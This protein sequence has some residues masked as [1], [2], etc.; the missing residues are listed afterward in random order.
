MTNEVYAQ[1]FQNVVGSGFDYL[2][3]GT[4]PSEMGVAPATKNTLRLYD[5]HTW[6]AA[7]A[8]KLGRFELTLRDFSQQ[9]ANHPEG[10]FSSN[11]NGYSWSTLT[12]NQRNELLG[13]LA[14]AS[15]TH[16]TI[17]GNKP[18]VH[19]AYAFSTLFVALGSNANNAL[20]KE[21]AG[22]ILAAITF[23][24]AGEICSLTN[25]LA[26][27]AE[28][29]AVG[30]VGQPVRLLS[31][32][33]G[34]VATTMHS[35]T[36]SCWGI[37]NSGINATSSSGAPT[38][39]M[40]CGTTVGTKASDATLTTAITVTKTG[41]NAGGKAVGAIRP[42]GGAQRAFWLFPKVSNTAGALKYGAET[43]MDIWS[44]DMTAD[45]LLPLWPIG[46]PSNY[47]P[48]GVINA[49][50]YREGIVY[51]DATH[52]VYWDGEHEYDLGL[53]TRRSTPSTN[54]NELAQNY[55]HHIRNVIVDGPNLYCIWQDHFYTALS[56]GHIYLEAYNYEAGSWHNFAKP[57]ALTTVDGTDNGTAVVL[58]GSGGIVV[59]P[60]SRYAYIRNQLDG[61]WKALYIPRAAESLLWQNS[62]G[63]GSDTTGLPGWTTGELLTTNW[64][65]DEFF[66]SAYRGTKSIRLLP[67][68]ITEVEFQGNLDYGHAILSASDWTLRVRV[69]GKGLTA[70]ATAYDQT[71]SYGA[72][73]E[74]YLKKN[75]VTARTNIFNVQVY[76]TAT[77]SPGSSASGQ[78][79]PIVIRGVY[80][81]DGKKITSLPEDVVA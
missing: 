57:I 13:A 45:D 72:P 2:T 40:Y 8:A 10:D 76:L 80:S 69:Q 5:D 44:S 61:N 62:L 29:L 36:N 53:L 23:S 15:D 66:P 19:Q 32:N 78:F 58:A 33:A 35:S 73:R 27:G 41:V 56:A 6:S 67:K 63:S 4:Q 3:A 9:G 26:A 65:L 28:R 52:I 79:L 68:V 60:T 38:M 16:G 7:N 54:P 30:E 55:K 47:C 22:T 12:T 74:D 71:F 48:N 24:P 64:W 77:N 51:W 14:T 46:R 81:K 11:S 17:S 37:I 1:P 39:L 49:E 42:K 59:S 50:P 31:D 18:G 43:M 25:V 21:T 34:T 75:P 70:Q 20:L